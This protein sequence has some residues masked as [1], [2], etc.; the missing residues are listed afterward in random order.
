MSILY[1]QLEGPLQSW[2]SHSKFWRRDTLPFPT[3][4]GVTG[5]LFC[6]MGLS[7][8]QRSRLSVLAQL[9]FEVVQ[10]QQSQQAVS[11]ALTDLQMVGSAYD[12][13]DPWEML[14][15]PRKS[16][17]KKPK[18]SG[19][20][21]TYRHYLQS[22]YFA[23]FIGI[24]DEWATEVESAMK[25]PKWDLYLG[26]KSCA[27]SSIIFHGIYASMLDAK[28]AFERELK[29]RTGDPWKVIRVVKEVSAEQ[30]GAVMLHDVPVQFGERKVYG[31]RFVSVQ[32]PK[33]E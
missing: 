5:L 3:R 16:D 12:E 17:G 7:G 22:A 10:Y 21:M 1:L 31:Y 24:P 8:P 14:L 29:G 15:V 30:P 20:K 32:V 27:P 6:A 26:R 25:C 11:R 18:N 23:A 9:P 2:G 19:V 33:S 13:S 4:S 28:E